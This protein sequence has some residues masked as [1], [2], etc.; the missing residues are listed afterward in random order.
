MWKTAFKKFVSNNN[1]NPCKVGWKIKSIEIKH[2]LRE[3]KLLKIHQDFNFLREERQSQR[4]KS[5][6]QGETY[7]FSLQYHQSCLNDQP[8]ELLQ[9]L[10]RQI[11]VQKPHVVAVT[12]QKSDHT[13]SNE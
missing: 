12:N 13:Y 10:E 3:K 7:R 2:I 8:V 6:Q 9:S 11:H 1:S 5:F 4:F